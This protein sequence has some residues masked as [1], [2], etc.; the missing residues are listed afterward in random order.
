[1]LSE[2]CASRCAVVVDFA[3]DGPER[4]ASNIIVYLPLVGTYGMLLLSIFTYGLL[5]VGISTL[6]WMG[7][8]DHQNV[9]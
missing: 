1:M 8:C 6:T 4:M 7:R 9:T 3:I 5:D 2:K